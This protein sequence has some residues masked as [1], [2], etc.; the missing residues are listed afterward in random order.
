ATRNKVLAVA[1]ELGYVP[2]AAAKMLVSGQTRTIGV[3]VSQAEHLQVDAFIPQVLYALSAYSQ[4]AGFRVLLETVQDVS[5]PDS[6]LELV[7]GHHIDGLIVINSRSDDVHLPD[8]CVVI[9]RW[10]CWVS[11]T[12][13][14]V[15]TPCIASRAT[16]WD[17]PESLPNT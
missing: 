11:L 2:N 12:G 10:C 8:W 15:R 13:P 5:Q 16:V 4:Q 7:K 14:R 6:Y 17:Q 9:T 3:V 1:S